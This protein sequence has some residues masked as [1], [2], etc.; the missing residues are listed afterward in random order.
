DHNADYNKRDIILALK[1]LRKG[2]S[3]L[4][5]C[6][7]I[8]NLEKIVS[9]IDLLNINWANTPLTRH[10]YEPPYSLLAEFY[11]GVC[12]MDKLIGI[13]AKEDGLKLATCR[14]F[15]ESA[16]RDASKSKSVLES[17]SFHQIVRDA[18]LDKNQEELLNEFIGLVK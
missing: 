9:E 3:T 11:M 17:E 6:Y 2:K 4:Y 16:L 18:R 15:L 12:G 7:H 8:R 13:W 5:L 1:H 10:H 14:V